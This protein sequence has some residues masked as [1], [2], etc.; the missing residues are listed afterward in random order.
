MLGVLIRKE[1]K[2]GRR[3]GGQKQNNNKRHK[4]TFEVDGH[5]YYLDCSHSN[6]C[7]HMSKLTKLYTLIMCILYTYYTSIKL[8]KVHCL[9][10]LTVHLFYHSNRL[11]Y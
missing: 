9:Y 11:T 2:E 4:E 6:T 8:E 3:E 10:L 7:L 1:G 5:V